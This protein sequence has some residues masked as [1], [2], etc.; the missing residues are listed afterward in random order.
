M[1]QGACWGRGLSP[2]VGMQEP[3]APTVEGQIQV[4]RSQRRSFVTHP[5]PSPL[6]AL[7][8]LSPS[9]HTCWMTCR[10]HSPGPSSSASGGLLG[11]RAAKIRGRELGVLWGVQGRVPLRCVLAP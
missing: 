8:S 10:G 3:G 9:T 6:M 11:C 7:H 1:S 2:W 4:L 5:S